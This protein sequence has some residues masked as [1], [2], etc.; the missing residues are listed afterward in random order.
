MQLRLLSVYRPPSAC[1]L[2]T[3]VKFSLFEFFSLFLFLAK[4]FDKNILGKHNITYSTSNYDI[5]SPEIR[6]I[7]PKLE[8]RLYA[9]T[10]LILSSC[11]AFGAIKPLSREQFQFPALALAR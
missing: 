5:S 3:R 7:E 10:L 4:A 11:F 1:V 6:D 9:K 8:Q 2:D